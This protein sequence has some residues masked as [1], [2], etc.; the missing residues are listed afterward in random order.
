MKALLFRA[1]P[2]Y[3]IV[4]FDK[5]EV[6]REVREGRLE[7]WQLIKRNSAETQPLRKSAG[8]L[9][10]GVCATL[11]FGFLSRRDELELLVK[12]FWNCLAQTRENIWQHAHLNIVV[13]FRSV[14][15][16]SVPWHRH[17]PFLLLVA[18]FNLRRKRLIVGGRCILGRQVWK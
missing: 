2:Y 13:W 16:I 14:F 10:T 5:L 12:S 4:T 7:K 3:I 6:W 9:I 1:S 8:D 11:R 17:L 18:A 15:S